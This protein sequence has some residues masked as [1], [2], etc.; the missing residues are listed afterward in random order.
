LGVCHGVPA[1][2]NW[3]G[4]TRNARAV[5]P[6]AKACPQ[7][8]IRDSYVGERRHQFVQ[9]RGPIGLTPVLHTVWHLRGVLPVSRCLPGLFLRAGEIPT[10]RACTVRP[11]DAEITTTRPSSGYM[12][13]EMAAELSAANAAGPIETRYSGYATAASNIARFGCFRSSSWS[14]HWPSDHTEN[15][16]FRARSCA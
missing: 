7:G 16:L 5:P 2:T 12:Y 9:S 13:P 15:R 10:R 6:A 1:A 11:D 8:A 3:C 4:T 14:R